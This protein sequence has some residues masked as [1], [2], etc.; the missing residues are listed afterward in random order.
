[1]APEIVIFRTAYHPLFTGGLLQV[2]EN[3]SRVP[4]FQCHSLERPWMDNEPYVSCIPTGRYRL[5]KAI[6]KISTPDPND[7]YEVYEICDVRDRTVIHI[8]I[9]NWPSQIEGCVALGMRPHPNRWG[10]SS[11]RIAF[12]L[13]MSAMKGREDGWITISDSFPYS[14]RSR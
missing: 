5:K 12:N 8:H 3:G 13:F 6:H 11:S 2:R 14:W 10:V 4:S 1:M 9:A 7:D